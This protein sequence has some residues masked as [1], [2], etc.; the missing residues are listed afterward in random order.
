M[1]NY[2]FNKHGFAVVKK[3][4]SKD[5]ATFCYNYLLMKEN[6]L[7][8]LQ[9]DQYISPDEDIH[10]LFGDPQIGNNV[11]NIYGDP[12]MDTLMLKCQSVME[13]ETKVPLIPTYTYARNYLNGDLKDT[14]TDQAVK[15]LAP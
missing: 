10:G 15:Y 3:A 8:Y 2:N 6:V 4:I 14:K 11:F 13:K 7:H 1:K 9:K 5:L 12:A